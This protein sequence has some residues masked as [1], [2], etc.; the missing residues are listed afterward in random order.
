VPAQINKIGVDNMINEISLLWLNKS[1]ESAIGERKQAKYKLPNDFIADLNLDLIAREININNPDYVLNILTEMSEDPN[2]IRY[3]QDILTDFLNVPELENVITDNINAIFRNDRTASSKVQGSFISLASRLTGIENYIACIDNFYVFYKENAKRI[4]SD[5]LKAFF[6]YINEVHDSQDFKTLV[7]ETANLRETLTTKISSITIGINFDHAMRPVESVLLSIGSKPF[8]EKSVL[9]RLFNMESD[10]DNNPYRI[11]TMHRLDPKLEYSGLDGAL[12]ND[13]K[14]ITHQVVNNFSNV[15]K[16]YYNINISLFVELH[17]QF[18]FYM[19]AAKMIKYYRS[20]GLEMCR[21]EIADMDERIFDVRNTC[22]LAFAARLKKDDYHMD[23]SKTIVLNDI[24]MSDKG[25][26]FILTGPNQGG[27]TTYTR[28]IGV[29]QVLFQAGLFIPGTYARISPVDWIYTHF[30]KEEV[31]GFQSS[32][33]S[34]ECRQFTD[35]FGKATCYSLIL[36]NESLQSTT[37][38]EGIYLSREVLKIIRYLGCRAV[39]TTHLLELV[40][41]IEGIHNEVDGDNKIISM[42][43]GVIKNIDGNAQS[44]GEGIKQ[45]YKVAPGM[46]FANSFAK[47]IADKYGVNFERL[48]DNINRRGKYNI[49]AII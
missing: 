47:Q 7:K 1:D 6:E 18:S 4:K 17:S 32:R 38:L 29:C 11:S 12:F 9:A 2:V 5:G 30:P 13:L 14:E 25:R 42:V 3:R 16:L 44:G 36:M 37:A 20:H 40:N 24:S 45:T 10:N 19:G 27:K 21:P 39:F 49:S 35:T 34:E 15:L 46:P 8:K 48:A 22:D 23:F 43:A 26:I 41:E 31:V 33:L 28:A